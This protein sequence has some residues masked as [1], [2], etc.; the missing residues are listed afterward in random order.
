MKM[1]KVNYIYGKAK[2]TITAK[3]VTKEEASTATDKKAIEL[4]NSLL[5]DVNKTCASVKRNSKLKR[6]EVS[7]EI[8]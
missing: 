2:W 1:Y 8:A 7:R 6:A 4:F 3:D 5:P